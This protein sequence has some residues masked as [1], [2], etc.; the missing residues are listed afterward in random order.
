MTGWADL[1]VSWDATRVGDSVLFSIDDPT[2]TTE[3]LISLDDAREVARILTNAAD[4]VNG[5]ALDEELNP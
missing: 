4:G 2:A 3:Y 1:E 5:D